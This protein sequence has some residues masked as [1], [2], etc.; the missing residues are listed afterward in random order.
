MF[1]FFHKRSYIQTADICIVD[2]ATQCTEPSTLLPLQLGVRSLVLVGDTQQLP[3]T[4]LSR[5]A[6]ELGL[7]KSLFDRV[8]GAFVRPEQCPTFRLNRQYRM[9]ADICSWPNRFFYGGQL[10][11]VEPAL[12]SEA[13]GSANGCVFPLRPYNVFSLHY[14]H[15]E[16][17]V[18]Y[19]HHMSNANEAD[20]V[21]RL[22]HVL[23]KIVTSTSTVGV[24]TP[25]AGQRDELNAKIKGVPLRFVTVDTI[26]AYQGQEKDIIIMSTTRSNGIGFLQTGQRLN[27]ALTRARKCMILCG[28]FNSLRVSLICVLCY[29][30]WN[31]LCIF[32]F[33]YYAAK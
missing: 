24:I 23:A 32:C 3:G 5:P 8:Q 22:L 9:H 31:Y 30:Y 19:Q 27:V 4:V 20:F 21:V 10:E 13:Q 7:S 14:S 17:R 12:A 16:R 28:N 29:S 11:T 25:Y 2:E 15:S 26:D 33:L 18:Q 6:A 1:F